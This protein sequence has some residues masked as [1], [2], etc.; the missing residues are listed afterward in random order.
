[1]KREPEMV[2]GKE[3]FT[4]FTNA[5]RKILSV[6]KERVQAKIDEQRRQSAANPNRP[7][8]KRKA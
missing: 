7:G 8:P 1:M 2:E 5:M 3:A 6:P 4:R